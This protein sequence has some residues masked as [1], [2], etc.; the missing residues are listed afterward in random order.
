MTLVLFQQPLQTS[1]P[2]LR[3]QPSRL[4]N[5]VDGTPPDTTYTPPSAFSYGLHSFAR[6]PISHALLIC[7]VVA[8]LLAQSPRIYAS[9]FSNYSW[10]FAFA[11][12]KPRKVSAGDEAVSPVK[13]TMSSFWANTNIEQQLPHVAVSEW[14]EMRPI[15]HDEAFCLRPTPTPYHLDVELFRDARDRSHG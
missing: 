5:I 12:R 11:Q 1:R 2:V 8:R 3:Y 7:I 10:R 13:K 15:T 14:P 6:D 4:L 9:V